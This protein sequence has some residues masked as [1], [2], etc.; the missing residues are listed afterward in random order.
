MSTAQ[1]EIKL[2]KDELK[3]LKKQ[4]SEKAE[5]AAQEGEK[6]AKM[7][8]EEMSRIAHGAGEG[9]RSF[10]SLKGEQL[11][12]A[13][14]SCEQTIQNRPFAST[15]IAFAGGVLVASLLSRK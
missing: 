11:G 6:K 10:V 3:E 5:N 8:K 2:L 12:N 1:Q 15:A 7:T 4:M 13:K 9:V 14:D